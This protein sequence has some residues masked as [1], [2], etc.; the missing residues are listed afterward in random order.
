[1][2]KG[3]IKIWDDY[4][5]TQLKKVITT[6]YCLCPSDEDVTLPSTS[7]VVIGINEIAR[8]EHSHEE[9]QPQDGAL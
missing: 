8:G 7:T 6:I 5:I 9:E 3:K 2:I 1:V 4:S